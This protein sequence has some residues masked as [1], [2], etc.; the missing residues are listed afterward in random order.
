MNIEFFSDGFFE[1]T[2]L[3]VIQ[4]LHFSSLVFFKYKI[5]LFLALL[6]RQTNN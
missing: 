4:Q 2:S 1:K 5:I 6:R 3:K